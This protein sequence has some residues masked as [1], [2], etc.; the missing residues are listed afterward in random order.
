MNAAT[1][2]TPQPMEDPA[3]RFEAR[4]V[5]GACYTIVSEAGS[6]GTVRYRTA[7]AELPVVANADGTFTIVD[8]R[9]RLVRVDARR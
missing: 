3:P 2:T 6:D 8:T 1:R 7:Y 4:S 5:T 9:T